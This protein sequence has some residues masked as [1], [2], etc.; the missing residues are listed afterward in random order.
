MS[1]QPRVSMSTVEPQ[2]PKILGLSDSVELYVDV[3]S[4]DWEDVPAMIL[5]IQKC[6]AAVLAAFSLADTPLELS[7]RL[8]DDA[9]IA[10]LN[11]E[12]RKQDKPTNVL[13]FSGFERDELQD[14]YD[15]AASDGPPVMLGDII[16]THGVT[17]REAR[18]QDKAFSDH[19]AHLVVHGLLHL[20]GFDHIEEEEANEMES[21]EKNIL[22]SLGIDDPY[23][24]SN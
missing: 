15:V 12:Y 21:H 6:V 19:M 18:E 5:L 8:T 11:R 24:G 14:A 7:V 23:V 13:S 1:D 2:L 22:A 10:H 17:S 20:M 9:D 3:A 16:I 4:D